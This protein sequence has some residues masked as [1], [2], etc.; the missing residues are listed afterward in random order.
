MNK[1]NAQLTIAAVGSLLVMGVLAGLAYLTDDSSNVLVIQ[2]ALGPVGIVAAVLCGLAFASYA[3]TEASPGAAGRSTAITTT[4]FVIVALLLGW[5]AYQVQSPV[6][7]LLTVVALGLAFL[8]L[9]YSSGPQSPPRIVRYLL[10]GGAFAAGVLPGF[11]VYIIL[12]FIVSDR[13]CQLTSS[14]CL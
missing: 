12:S 3:S 14:K 2:Q 4:G 13:Y 1:R 7:A 10:L 9:R 8:S 6:A 11:I 5:W